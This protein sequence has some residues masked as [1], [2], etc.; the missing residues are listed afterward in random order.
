MG[1]V[2]LP[3]SLTEPTDREVARARARFYAGFLLGMAAS[4]VVMLLTQGA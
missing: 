3:I 4:A 1:E 2:R